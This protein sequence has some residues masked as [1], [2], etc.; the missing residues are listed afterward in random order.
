MS[1]L[2]IAQKTRLAARKLAVLSADAKNQ[3]IEAIA[4]ALEVA[5]PSIVTANAADCKAAE[6]DGI[7]KPLYDRL[8][9][10]EVKWKSA[11]ASVRD[12]CNSVS[13]MEVA[14]MAQIGKI[15]QEILD[16]KDDQASRSICHRKVLI[17]K[18][19]GF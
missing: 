11:I 6:A 19:L 16:R 4:L 14:P 12:V 18:Q 5:A 2:E 1:I 15:K 17:N 3:A 9:L 7:A 10:D 13:P 8:K